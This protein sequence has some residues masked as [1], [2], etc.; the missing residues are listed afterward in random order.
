M[1]G[2]TE[3]EPGRVEAPPRP[4]GTGFNRQSQFA[5]NVGAA[6]EARNRAI[7]VLDHRDSRPGPVR[8][9]S[10]RPACLY[11]RFP[12]GF[13]SKGVHRTAAQQVGEESVQCPARRGT[14]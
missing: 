6:A 9:W 2:E 7:P 10:E 14:R 5:E 13:R 3:G 12:Q 8:G 1:R 11:E 4:P